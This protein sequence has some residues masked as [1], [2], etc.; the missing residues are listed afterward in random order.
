MKHDHFEL[1]TIS[2]EARHNIVEKFRSK[3]SQDDL[4][5][6]YIYHLPVF[7]RWNNRNVYGIVYYNGTSFFV[8]NI[9]RLKRDGT[10]VRMYVDLVSDF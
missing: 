2:S 1:E 5:N 3:Y 9:Y 10:P 7:V 8:S 4:K 6:I